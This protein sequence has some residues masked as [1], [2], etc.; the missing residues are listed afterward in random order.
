MRRESSSPFTR[1]VPLPLWAAVAIP[2][3]AAVLAGVVGLASGVLIG[4]AASNAPAG[5]GAP[6]AVVAA[7][8]AKPAA[9]ADP[10]TYLR[11]PVN[12]KAFE[13]AVMG[14]STREVTEMLGPPS[15]VMNNLDAGQGWVYETPP[16]TAYQKSKKQAGNVIL[17]LR[18]DHVSQI[19][20]NAA[21]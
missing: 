2:V 5:P 11:D 14:K 19:V 7:P 16:V 18:S 4:R 9:K 17:I 10:K 15:R 12:R 3:S 8:D 1:P 6:P 13:Q 21:I 20:W